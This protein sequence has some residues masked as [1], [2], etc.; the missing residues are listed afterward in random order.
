MNS[1][2]QFCHCNLKFHVHFAVVNKIKGSTES[3]PNVWLCSL[4]C[5]PIID[6]KEFTDLQFKNFKLHKHFLLRRHQTALG[7]G[8]SC[9][10]CLLSLSPSSISYRVR[11]PLCFLFFFPPL[12]DATNISVFLHSISA[13]VVR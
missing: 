2:Q 10:S 6:G 13:S 5:S 7:A 4:Q 8:T 3:N 1:P 9:W 11:F 12:Y